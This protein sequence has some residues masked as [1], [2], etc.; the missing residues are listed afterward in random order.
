MKLSIQ[1]TENIETDLDLTVPKCF[2]FGDDEKIIR[3]AEENGLPKVTYATFI[4]M[5]V[6]ELV[7]RKRMYE[8]E[9]AILNGNGKYWSECSEQHF[10]NVLFKKL[11]E[12]GFTKNP[13]LKG[14]TLYMSP[15]NTEQANIEHEEEVLRVQMLTHH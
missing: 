7:V 1:K 13:E 6:F 4:G 15:E 12:N 10:N 11:C 3:F 14:G 8:F 2:V 5:E 9:I